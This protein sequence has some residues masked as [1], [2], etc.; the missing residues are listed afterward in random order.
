MPN[1]V[2]VVFEFYAIFI[3]TLSDF[4]QGLVYSIYGGVVEPWRSGFWVVDY[5]E[6]V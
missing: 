2:E 4:G 5:V 3:N 6:R 1:G